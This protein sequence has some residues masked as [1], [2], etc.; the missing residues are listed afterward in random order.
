MWTV[1]RQFAALFAIC[2]RLKIKVK[3]GQLFC[4]YC[5]LQFIRTINSFIWT[6]IRR[7]QKFINTML[8]IPVMEGIVF[9]YIF[10]AISFA[11]HLNEYSPFA[12]S[13]QLIRCFL[14]A[15]VNESLVNNRQKIQGKQSNRMQT[16]EV[17]TSVLPWKHTQFLSYVRLFVFW[18]YAVWCQQKFI[19]ICDK[20][21][22]NNVRMFQLYVGGK[23]ILLVVSVYHF[24]TNREAGIPLTV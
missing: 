4:E 21:T 11:G 6:F 2:G 24:S 5:Y 16:S 12:C 22:V 7:S 8:S 19:Y 1:I 17:W 10:K 20:S 14:F 15:N 13:Q 9:V 18:L 3:F 23:R